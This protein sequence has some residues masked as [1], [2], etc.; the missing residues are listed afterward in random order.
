[1][2]CGSG[3]NLTPGDGQAA[4][5]CLAASE[6]VYGV[7]IWSGMMYRA[8]DLGK[9]QM[10]R[11]IVG[12]IAEYVDLPKGGSCLDVGCGSGALAIAKRNPGASN[13]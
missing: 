8:F 2:D 7:S 1:M 10:S 5:G 6:P 11:Q 12:G 4:D 9:R 13:E 3:Q